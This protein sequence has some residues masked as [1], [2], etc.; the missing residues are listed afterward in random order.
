[1]CYCDNITESELIDNIPMCWDCIENNKR[2][3]CVTWKRF[4]TYKTFKH[5]ETIH[6]FCD[7]KYISVSA[8]S[9][10]CIICHDS[11]NVNIK[12]THCKQT[13]AHYE[14]ILSWIYRSPTCPNCRTNLHYNQQS[15]DHYHPL[16]R[17][18]VIP[19]FFDTRHN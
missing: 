1:M 14:C 2:Y 12:C 11:S 6:L 19:E 9:D 15:H 4:N 7:L 16:S 3:Y 13:I 5:R 18:F 10:Q 17:G 8:S